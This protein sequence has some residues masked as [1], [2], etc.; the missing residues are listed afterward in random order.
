MA[1]VPYTTTTEV[2][3]PFVETE[4]E[5]VGVSAADF[6][7]IQNL[8]AT[9]TGTGAMVLATSPTLVT[10]T[11]GVATATSVNKVTITAPATSAT[12]TVANGK[13][14]TVSNT[15]TFTG[16]DG[17]SVA[18]GTGGTV[19]YTANKLD[20]FA[21]TTSA[22]LAGVI[23]DETGT[24]ALVFANTPTL[25]TPAIG[26]AT[27]TSAVLTSSVTALSATPATAGGF[28]TAGVV[29]GN[30]G[31]GIFFGSGAPSI[32]AAKGSLYMRTDGSTT[33][34]RVYVNTDA[35]TTWT[36]ITTAA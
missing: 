5:S 32:T 3:Y 36:A 12:L 2:T 9:Q 4:L 20:A 6:A 10:P 7:A 22:E 28:A 8:P 26:A 33:N 14:A 30:A 24:G 35:G 27:G 21:A 16:T 29:L 13:T 31:L 19:A 11:I 15:L 25:V 34:D 18:C 17:S 1:S 23:S